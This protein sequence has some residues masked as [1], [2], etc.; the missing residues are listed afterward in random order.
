M[1]AL[2]VDWQLFSSGEQSGAVNKAIAE[3][4]KASFQLD[5]ALNTLRLSIIQAKRAEELAR[6]EYES[7]QA[8]TRQGRSI[9]NTLKKRYGRG[10]VP[11]GSVLESQMKVTQA[12]SQSIQS[13]YN[14][15]LAQGRLLLLTNQLIPHSDK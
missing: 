6:I 7:N 4:K 11:L 5:D 14:Q 2:G 13:Q 8:N 12:Q 9:V 15:K 3:V 10:L 1:I